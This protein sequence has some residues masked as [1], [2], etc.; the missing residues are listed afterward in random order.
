MVASSC[1]ASLM[2]RVEV[3]VDVGSFIASM[4]GHFGAGLLRSR[5][6]I[7]LPHILHVHIL[8]VVLELFLCDVVVLH[9]HRWMLSVYLWYL[10]HV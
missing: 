4:H 10:P 8:V 6:W 5:C 9:G 3:D 7:S 2:W 1:G